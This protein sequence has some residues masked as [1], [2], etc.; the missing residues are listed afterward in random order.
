MLKCPYCEEIKAYLIKM[1]VVLKAI[2]D[3]GREKTYKREG[4]DKRG[5]GESICFD[6]LKFEAEEVL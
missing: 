3:D 1:P 5:L 2:G 4:F 6:C